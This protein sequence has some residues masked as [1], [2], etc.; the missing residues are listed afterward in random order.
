LRCKPGDLAL[1]VEGSAI[2]TFVTVKE[3]GILH[4]IHR[5]PSWI[6]TVSAPC[7]VTLIEAY[8]MRVIRHSIA[9]AGSL[10]QFLDRELQ[11]I[12][13]PPAPIAIPAPPQALE[14][15]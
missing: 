6:C 1:V 9:P 7:K 14:T 15:A 2:G 10:V 13:P 3:P 8:T 5:L 4:P 12:R 11:P